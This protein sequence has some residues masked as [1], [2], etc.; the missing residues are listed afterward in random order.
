MTAADALNAL[1]ADVVSY[2]FWMNHLVLNVYGCPDIALD[3]DDTAPTECRTDL[4]NFLWELLFN[5]T[6]AI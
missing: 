3:I 5:G 1:K 4:C 2:L 6:H